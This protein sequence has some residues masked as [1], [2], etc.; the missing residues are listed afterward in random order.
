MSWKID[1]FHL[2]TFAKIHIVRFVRFFLENLNCPRKKITKTRQRII[3]DKTT[4]E[5]HFSLLC[6]CAHYVPAP[7]CLAPFFPCLN[8]VDCFKQHLN[9]IEC[10]VA[11]AVGI[12]NRLKFIFPKE[13][14]LQ[15]YHALIYFMHFQCGVQH[16]KSIL[17]QNGMINHF[18]PI[19]A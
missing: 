8:V 9:D 7:L 18:L 2:I 15:L 11:C 16:T 19:I 6:T 14:L 17:E 12:M 13:T 4:K 1:F 10:K 3:S 5:M